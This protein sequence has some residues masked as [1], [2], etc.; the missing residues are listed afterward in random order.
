MKVPY[1]LL[2][3]SL[4]SLFIVS[5]TFVLVLFAT[6]MIFKNKNIH[7]FNTSKLNYIIEIMHFNC[8][9]VKN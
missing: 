7:L 4:Q 5:C 3:I 2:L 1:R 6:S 9:N 8:L